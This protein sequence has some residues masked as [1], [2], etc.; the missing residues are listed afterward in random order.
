MRQQLDSFNDFINTSLQVRRGGSWRECS[1]VAACLGAGECRGSWQ[2]ACIGCL[3]SQ[4][5]QQ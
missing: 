2:T 4:Q 1:P 5:Q 3:H